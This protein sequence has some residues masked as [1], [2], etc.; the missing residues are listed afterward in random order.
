MPVLALTRYAW[1]VL[2]AV[3]LAILDAIQGDA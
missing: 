2:R 1:P 3:G